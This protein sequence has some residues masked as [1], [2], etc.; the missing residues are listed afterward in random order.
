MQN[1]S[2]INQCFVNVVIR[3]A[4][5][6]KRED[7]KGF[8]PY[9]ALHEYTLWNHVSPFN[10]LILVNC[11]NFSKS[12]QKQ[13]PRLAKSRAIR[14]NSNNQPGRQ[15]AEAKKAQPSSLAS[16]LWMGQ[17]RS[18]TGRQTTQVSPEVKQ[19]RPEYEP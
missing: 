8:Y 14:M 5:E 1:L 9:K 19:R 10:Y 13:R 17:S 11:C 6:T 4:K 3:P 12:K 18:V 15:Y 2:P 16:C 7:G